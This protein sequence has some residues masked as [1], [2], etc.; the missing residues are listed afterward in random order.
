MYLQ[1]VKRDFGLRESSAAYQRICAQAWL[2]SARTESCSTTV[3]ATLP[4]TSS[5]SLCS[6][7][8][9]YPEGLPNLDYFRGS[10]VV[11][12]R[13]GF[14]RYSMHQPGPLLRCHFDDAGDPEACSK[15][16]NLWRLLKIMGLFRGPNNLESVLQD[17]P[18]SVQ[19]P[20]KWRR[21]TLRR[22]LFP[23]NHAKFS[24]SCCLAKLAVE[25]FCG[26]NRLDGTT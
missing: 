21:R 1:R 19:G 12:L 2:P 7:R 9:F 5:R 8:R 13:L 22:T 6:L 10:G 4:P 24:F 15:P 17:L 25:C 26:C 3:L 20:L 11:I 23:I 14:P 18:G 16:F